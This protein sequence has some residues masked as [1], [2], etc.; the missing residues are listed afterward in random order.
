MTMSLNLSVRDKKFKAIDCKGR[1]GYF[2]HGFTQIWDSRHSEN[3]PQAFVQVF[4]AR[5]G[6][7]PPLQFHGKADDLI[8]YFESVLKSLR[9]L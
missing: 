5:R 8:S 6:E 4:S 3:P 7:H 2:R 9:Q 1:N